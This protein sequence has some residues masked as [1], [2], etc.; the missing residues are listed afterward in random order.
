[1]KTRRKK[2][3]GRNKTLVKRNKKTAAHLAAANEAVELAKKELDSQPTDEEVF[4]KL[5]ERFLSKF[6]EELRLD[7]IKV[8][9]AAALAQSLLDKL[10]GTL[11]TDPIRGQL[12]KKEID[13]QPTED[14][15]LEGLAE[16]MMLK[17]GFGANEHA[18]LELVETMKEG[19][20]SMVDKSMKE[21]PEPVPDRSTHVQSLIKRTHDRFE[22][23]TA[24]IRN[25]HAKHIDASD[26]YPN[27]IAFMTL[28]EVGGMPI[29]SKLYASIKLRLKNRTVGAHQYGHADHTVSLSPEL[30]SFHKYRSSR[31][32]HEIDK[33]FELYTLSHILYH[34]VS[35]VKVHL[36]YKGGVLQKA[37]IPDVHG[38]PNL[39]CMTE[40]EYN[41]FDVTPTFLRTV[42]GYPLTIPESTRSLVVVGIA[43]LPRQEDED[44]EYVAPFSHASYSTRTKYV[45]DV[46]LSDDY[47]SE[48]LCS[49]M[50]FIPYNFYVDGQPQNTHE[51]WSVNLF[52]TL[53]REYKFPFRPIVKI[54]TSK[55]CIDITFTADSLLIKAAGDCN[56]VDPGFTPKQLYK[57]IIEE[58]HDLDACQYDCDGIVLTLNSF[59]HRDH[60]NASELGLWPTPDSGPIRT[61]SYEIAIEDGGPVRDTFVNAVSWK[62]GIL[63][64]IVPVVHVKPVKIDNEVVSAVHFKTIFNFKYA[65]LTINSKVQIFLPAYGEPRLRRV[66][67]TDFF[68][69]PKEDR[70]IE[71]PTSCPRCRGSV[72]NDPP[73]LLCV[74]YCKSKMKRSD[75]KVCRF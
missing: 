11:S 26:E 25:E 36:Y 18:Y 15:L 35:G 28:C 57:R 63:N 46:L 21:D 10:P 8:D 53:G 5:V 9:G 65:N 17:I 14:E 61:P 70:K 12:P 60:V 73:L 6:T 20:T 71:L 54:V 7:A 58:I 42:I 22:L 32:L 30:K 38:T 33:Y 52:E 44:G 4:E 64:T 47:D 75:I 43:T 40:N 67:D 72:K 16:R 13:S 59:S 68:S 56:V 62:R 50:H 24:H 49:D 74:N 34:K 2:G 45:K 37:L 23:S 31:I 55:G 51:F 19:W 41:A 69:P 29:P 39:K 48:E 3:T 66:Y 27:L 1:M